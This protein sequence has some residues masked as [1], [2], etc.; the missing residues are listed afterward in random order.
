MDRRWFLTVPLG[1]LALAGGWFAPRLLGAG[2]DAPPPAPSAAPPA[3]PPDDGPLAFAATVDRDRTD[4]LGREVRIHV[5]LSASADPSADRVPTDLVVVLDRSGSMAGT[6]LEDARAATRALVDALGP[7]DRLALVSFG[8]DA[9]LDLPLGR[10][11]KAWDAVIDRLSAGGSTDLLDGLSTARPQAAVSAG[12]ATRLILL[13]DGRPDQRVEDLLPAVSRIAAGDVPVTAVGIGA[14]WDETLMRRLA[15][16][17]AGNLRWV[18]QGPDLRTTLQ[19]ELAAGSRVVAQAATLRVDGPVSV[20]GAAGYPSTAR[21]VRL[22]PVVAGAR[23]GLWVTLR[24]DG[25]RTGDV[26]LGSVVLS[27]RDADGTVREQ[28]V[29]LPT[30][31]VD[32]DATAAYAALGDEWAR[33][34]VQEDWNEVRQEV[35]ARVQSGDQDGA[36]SVLD[37]YRQRYALVNGFARNPIVDDNLGE[38]AALRRELDDVFAQD[39]ARRNAWSKGNLV[40]STADRKGGP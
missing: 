36:R 30:V 21:E 12:R 26:D 8:S 19:D 10:P 4:A 18:Q 2:P 14:D 27:T 16:A 38:A 39:A 7:D 15:D 9:T 6:K 20:V 24:V 23:R 25:A 5:D 3:A 13:S 31:A 28:R 1:S 32:A 17:G 37:G 35:S 29:A 33:G 22:G 40:S 34:V 11:G